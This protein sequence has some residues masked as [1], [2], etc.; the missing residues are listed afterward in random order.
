MRNL[1]IAALVMIAGSSF[2]GAPP[3]TALPDAGSSLALLAA[4]CGGMVFTKR[5]F[6]KSR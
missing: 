5:F 3:P 4:A 1:V 2:A 6:A